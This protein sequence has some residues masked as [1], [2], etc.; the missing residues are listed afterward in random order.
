ML[1]NA[2]PPFCTRRKAVTSCAHPLVKGETVRRARLRE[3]LDRG[4]GSFD[5]IRF[6]DAIES[7]DPTDLDGPLPK[8][9]PALVAA[10]VANALS[11]DRCDRRCILCC[12]QFL[13]L[14]SCPFSTNTC[15]LRHRRAVHRSDRRLAVEAACKPFP[16]LAIRPSPL[17]K[18]PTYIPHFRHEQLYRSHFVIRS[19]SRFA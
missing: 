5:C 14:R 4:G 6:F 7:H 9:C 19:S 1:E 13:S 11:D 10:Y 18:P 15:R 8:P 12:P 3:P 16:Q 2:T 17:D